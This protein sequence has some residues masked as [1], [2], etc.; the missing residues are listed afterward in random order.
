MVERERSQMVD[1]LTAVFPCGIILS[2]NPRL[3]KNRISV[4]LGDRC[5]KSLQIFI[6]LLSCRN[7]RLIYCVKRA[8][9]FKLTP[10]RPGA[11]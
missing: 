3:L 1:Y 10:L 8:V 7:I 11:C 9:L 6:R 5:G 4:L 2:I